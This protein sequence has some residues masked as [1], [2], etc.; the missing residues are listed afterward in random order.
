[1]RGQTKSIATKTTKCQSF[2][3]KKI[4]FLVMQILNLKI[5]REYK[6]AGWGQWK[7]HFCS[8]KKNNLKNISLLVTKL[9]NTFLYYT[10]PI[11]DDKALPSVQQDWNF[12]KQISVV[13]ET[14][15]KK[16]KII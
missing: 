9:H 12:E 8:V 3:I 2:K 11:D 6:K 16:L 10:C 4:K 7:F 15:Q 13:F 14:K 1:M 5:L